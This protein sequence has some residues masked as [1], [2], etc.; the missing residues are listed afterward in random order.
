MIEK[1]DILKKEDEIFRILELE[2]EKVFVI[3]CTKQKMPYFAQ[4]EEFERAEKISEEE[5]LKI[6][7]TNFIDELSEELRAVVEEKMEMIKP[8]LVV[9]TDIKTRNRLIEI[10]SICG[11]CY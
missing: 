9:L 2:D 10:L 11:V 4:R 8:L 1:F 3:C 6:L 7:G 5:L